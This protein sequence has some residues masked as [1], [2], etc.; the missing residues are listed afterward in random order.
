[1][2]ES[3]AVRIDIDTPLSLRGLMHLDGLL[4]SHAAA[5]GKGATDIPLQK[6]E[7]IWQGSAAI[8]ETGPFGALV[9]GQSRVKHV[10]ADAVP[11]DIFDHLK[12][13]QRKIGRMSPMRHLLSSYPSFEG[14]RAVL[15]TGRG[16]PEAVAELLHD[17]R[18]LGAMG[19]TGYGRV[20]HLELI[21]V[22]G[23]TMS[24]LVSSS[25]LPTRTVPIEPWDR[26][27]LGRPDAAIISPPYWT[28]PE[29]ACVSPMQVDLSGT[30]GDIRA[31]VG[32][33]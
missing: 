8:L 7:G 27:D 17:A 18:N 32:A 26:F 30:R 25:G 28:G 10:V 23:S 22:N 4:G 19:R 3:F 14:I 2:T 1:M 13:A 20:T 16:D 9:A 5:R 21:K 31:I 29:V 6:H 12:P 24:G 15:F 11:D 33:S